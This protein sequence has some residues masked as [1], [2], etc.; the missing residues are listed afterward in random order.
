MKLISMTDYVITIEKGM[1]STADISK[2]K[3]SLIVGY[4]KFLKQ[5]LTLGMFVPCDENGKVLID[6][7]KNLNLINPDFKHVQYKEAQERV[8]FEGFNHIEGGVYSEYEVIKIKDIECKAIEDLVKEGC[9][10]TLTPNAIKTR[11]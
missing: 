3:L 9:Y 2:E 5:P 10:L 7:S 11:L 8:L 1:L 6:P 4:A